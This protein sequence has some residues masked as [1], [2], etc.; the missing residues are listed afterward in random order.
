MFK[1]TFY[2]IRNRI[3]GVHKSNWDF[4]AESNKID[5]IMSFNTFDQAKDWMA[6]YEV[7]AEKYYICK[8]DMEEVTSG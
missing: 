1:S 5:D 8:W 2:T 4:K 7:S 6:F 3:T